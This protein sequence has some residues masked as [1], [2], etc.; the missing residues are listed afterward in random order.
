MEDKKKAPYLP[1]A[2]DFFEQEPSDI[3]SHSE[4]DSTK[5]PDPVEDA[6]VANN[7]S[8]VEFDYTYGGLDEDE[9]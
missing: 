6:I 2:R 3:R 1:K 5:L 8:N 7:I 9:T 4:K